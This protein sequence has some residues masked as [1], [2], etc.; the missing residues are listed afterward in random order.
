MKEYY[1]ILRR[2]TINENSVYSVNSLFGGLFEE[3]SEEEK[4]LLTTIGNDNLKLGQS[5]KKEIDSNTKRDINI[6]GEYYSLYCA[7]NKTYQI[8]PPTLKPNFLLNITNLYNFYRKNL[9][10]DNRVK[11]HSLMKK[12]LEYTDSA[13]TLDIL[14]NYVFDLQ[15]KHGEEKSKKIIDITLTKF[16][17]NGVSLGIEKFLNSIKTMAHKD[18]EDSFIG[19]HFESYRTRLELKRID[20]N[21]VLTIQ[22]MVDDVYDGKTTVEEVVQRLYGVIIRNYNAE[23]MVK[24][25]LICKKP[26]VDVNGKIIVG[27]NQYVEVKKIDYET[28]SYLSEFMAL[29]KKSDLPKRT[30]EPKYKNIYNQIIDGLYKL[31]NK[32][33]D[34]NTI[35]GDSILNDIKNN[36]FAGIMYDNNIFI[37]KEYVTLYWSNKGQRGCDEHR[38]SIRYRI[39]GG[40]VKGY[41]YL[42]QDIMEQIK[43][44]EIPQK[45]EI[46]CPITTPLQ[47]EYRLDSFTG[48]LIEGRVDD[49]RKKYSNVS[50]EVFNYY[51]ENDPSNNHKYLDWLLKVNGDVF[52]EVNDIHKHAIDNIKFFHQYNQSF[53]NKDINTYNI[54]TLTDAVQEVKIKLLERETEKEAKK[55]KS[56]IYKDDKWL[57]VSPHTWQASCVFGLGTRW[58]ITMKNTSS[59]WDRYSRGSTFFFITD[60]TKPNTDPM[61]KVAYRLIGKKGKYELW[62][63][64]DIEITKSELGYGYIDSLP[65]EMRLK[66]DGHHQKQYTEKDG[67]ELNLD[68]PRIQVLHNH[69]DSDDIHLDTVNSYYGLPVYIIDGGESWC[70]GDQNEMDLAA[71]RYYDE[72][73]DEELIDYYDNQGYYLEMNNEERFIDDEVD[74]YMN[75]Q[76]EMDLLKEYGNFYEWEELEGEINNLDQSDVDYEEKYNRLVTQQQELVESSLEKVREDYRVE[77]EHCF[78]NGP[79]ECLVNEKG[80][81]RNASDIYKSRLVSLDRDTLVEYLTDGSYDN[82]IAYEGYEYERDNDGNW[83]YLFKIDI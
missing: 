38:L 48:L 29:Y 60:K 52:Y 53:K 6:D 66:I 23:N 42:A 39:N 33:D 21:E 69:L 36:N 12:I 58:C 25:D 9:I 73:G 1:S 77:W 61:Y 56:V 7:L 83:W 76:D 4:E 71:T 68:D 45:P 64:E 30:K 5:C 78:R 31:F 57:V 80:W 32:K 27:E 49:A 37:P 63:A 75:D 51:V 74:Y 59:Y 44:S 28:D 10:R 3:Y 24:A 17:K 40:S 82:N 18:Y 15:S 34:K 11:F 72:Y 13:N 81:F 43:S 47:E 19:D 54:S 8:L 2:N 70:V 35:T 62:N 22:K 14:V 26:L 67:G 65:E 46:S 55:Q 41:I 50:D 79:V 16:K 20:N